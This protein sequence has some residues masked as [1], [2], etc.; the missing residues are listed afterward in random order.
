MKG[1]VKIIIMLMWKKF[2]FFSLEREKKNREFESNPGLPDGLFA[3]QKF[4][5][6]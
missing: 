3:N 1:A 6:G 5:S 2:Y 4:T